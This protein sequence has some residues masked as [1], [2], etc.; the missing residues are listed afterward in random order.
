MRIGQ[1]YPSSTPFSQGTLWTPQSNELLLVQPDWTA[2][3]IVAFSRPVRL[4]LLAH[5]PLLVLLLDFGEGLS[6]E[7]LAFRMLDSEM[8]DWCDDTTSG[9][10]LFR[11]VI[12]D[13]HGQIVRHLRAFTVSP[14]FTQAARREAKARWGQ[15]ITPQEAEATMLD[16]QQANPDRKALLRNTIASS[17]GGD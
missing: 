16:F 5:G 15:P 4:H 1:P 17:R 13:L 11:L 7:L 2:D 6:V 12:V 10:L 8:P 3:E 9:H 14:H